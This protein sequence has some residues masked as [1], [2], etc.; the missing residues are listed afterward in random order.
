MQKIFEKEL[1]NIIEPF[2]EKIITKW[3]SAYRKHYSSGHVILRLI[4]NWKFKLD[5]GKFVGTVLMDLSKAFDFVPHD[6]LIAKMHAY[7][8]DM[9]SLIFF[10]SYLKRRKQCVKINN[11]LSSFQF[12]ISGVPQ[13][14]NLGPILFN[15]FINDL[16]LWIKESELYNF[17]DDNTLSATA[18]TIRDLITIL[19]SESEI[20]L[21]WFDLNEMLANA[22]K[23]QAMILNRCGR[24]NDT[25]DLRIG[26]FTIRSKT[27]VELLGIDIDF[28]LN[29]NKYVGKLCKKAAGQLNTLGRHL[30]FIDFYERK[31]LT[32]CFVQSNFN[33]CPLVWFF[34]SPKSIRKI[35]SI[36]E[37]ALRLLFQDYTRIYEDI[38]TRNGKNKFSTKLHICLAKEIYKTLNDLNPSYM[39]EVFMKN[40]RESSRHPND[41][42]KQGFK[43]ITYGQRSLRHL[44]PELWNKLPEEIKTASSLYTFKNLMKT[45]TNI[46]CNCRM[47]KALG[48]KSISDEL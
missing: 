2:V 24:H 10:Y 37:R 14:S 13:G 36:Q 1:K 43:G 47:C 18:D 34:T 25:H 27:S 22:K 4:E 6:L 48:L 46:N 12:L 23:F 26:D 5:S 33:F 19:E 38:L 8:F 45:W 41:L 40:C 35:E 15:I 44:G 9:N 30:H 20:A 16:F 17:A 21:N 7:G 28:K 11:F 3:I 42:I 39:K 32:E 31:A 29:F